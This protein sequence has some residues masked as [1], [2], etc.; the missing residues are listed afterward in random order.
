VDLFEPLVED[1]PMKNVVNFEVEQVL[2]SL[3]QLIVDGESERVENKEVTFDIFGK[4]EPL[5]EKHP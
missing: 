2:A 5:V 3:N 1:T 4:K